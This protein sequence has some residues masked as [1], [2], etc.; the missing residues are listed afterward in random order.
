MTPLDIEALEGGHGSQGLE[1]CVL[2]V[3]QF[4][5]T[6]SSLSAMSE[7]I[8]DVEGPLGVG[9]WGSVGE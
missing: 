3:Y 4:Q 1:R 5:R 6:L 9:N 7:H 8:K 2:K